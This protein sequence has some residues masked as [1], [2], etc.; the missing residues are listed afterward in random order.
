MFTPPLPSNGYIYSFL[1]SVFLAIMPCYLT[2]LSIRNVARN[3]K[4]TEKL[5]Y[6]QGA[7]MQDSKTNKGPGTSEN[8][9]VLWS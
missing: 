6:Y 8:S 9:R 1:Y 2:V 3:G 5:Y 7:Y 4:L